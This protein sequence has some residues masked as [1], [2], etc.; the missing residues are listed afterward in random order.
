[1]KALGGVGRL[2]FRMDGGISHLLLDEF[3]DTSLPQ[4][5]ALRPFAKQIT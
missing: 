4:W 3:Q 1:L 2:A 5:E